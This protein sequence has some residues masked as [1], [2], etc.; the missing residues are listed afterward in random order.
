[1]VLCFTLAVACPEQKRPVYK[2]ALKCI[3]KSLA[4]SQVT[5]FFSFYR[6]IICA[7]VEK[8]LWRYAVKEWQML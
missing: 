1:M 8:D 5:F 6:C 4:F 7:L 3:F 2:E